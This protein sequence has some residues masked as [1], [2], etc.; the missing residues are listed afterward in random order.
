MLESAGCQVKLHYFE[1]TKPTKEEMIDLLQGVVAVIAG[2]EPLT[3]RVLEAARD[4][5]IIARTG[6]GTDNV[7]LEAARAQGIRV[8]TTPGLNSKAVADLAVGLV[9]ALARRICSSDRSL[10]QGAWKQTAG[11]DLEGKILGI[12]GLGSIG[13]QVAR[14]AQAFDMRLVA[15]DT[16]HDEGFA[17]A[18]GISFVGCDE[19]LQM[20]DFVTLHLPLTP[21]TRGLIGKR[22]LRQ[23]KPTAYLVNTARGGIVD[24]RA[25]YEAL[26][27]GWIA[28]AG[29][30][31][32]AQEPPFGSPLLELDN[33]VVTPHIGAWTDGAWAAMARQAATEVI[34]AL[35]G[36]AALNPV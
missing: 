27:Q 22:E 12:V 14:R 16:V 6:I 30:D 15:Y 11:L 8:T 28:G 9:L 2:S 26:S 17:A 5:K 29:L 4:L 18:H 33:V 25:L 7:D 21:E 35:K 31:V 1:G 20:S 32:F 24:E 34:R 13:K 23:M 36:E 10:R 19:L 3:R